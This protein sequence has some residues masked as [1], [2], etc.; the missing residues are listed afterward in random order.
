MIVFCHLF[1]IYYPPPLQF[2]NEATVVCRCTPP[3]PQSNLELP[4]CALSRVTQTRRKLGFTHHTG[5]IFLHANSKVTVSD[6]ALNHL[7][8]QL[9]GNP[10]IKHTTQCKHVKCSEVWAFPWA[11]YCTGSI[12]YGSLELKGLKH[13]GR[14]SSLY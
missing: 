6:L 7:A 2:A 1:I 14:M 9:H 4:A 8:A 11:L 5:L 3:P 12:Y 13:M 10:S